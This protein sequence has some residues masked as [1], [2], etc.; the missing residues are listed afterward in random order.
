[1][2]EW[3]NGNIYLMN[4]I[5]YES[6]ITLNKAAFQYFDDEDFCILGIDVKNKKV[7][8]KAVSLRDVELKL[9]DASHLNKLSKGKG[10]IRISNKTFN[11]SVAEVL[12]ESLNGQKFKVD[13]DEK[14]RMLVVDLNEPLK[15]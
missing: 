8:I 12:K 4:A 13:Y 2:F 14:E 7:A 9:V 11:K 1:M 10:Y 15:G 6:N 5:F 3:F